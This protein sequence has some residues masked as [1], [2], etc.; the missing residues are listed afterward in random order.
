MDDKTGQGLIST[1]V[2]RASITEQRVLGVWRVPYEKRSAIKC[3]LMIHVSW[4]VRCFVGILR[5]ASS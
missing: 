3:E 2:R 1:G 5:S 4:D